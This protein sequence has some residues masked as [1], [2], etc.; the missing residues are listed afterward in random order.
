MNG[1]PKTHASALLVVIGHYDN[2][3]YEPLNEA[4][5]AARAL[6]EALGAGGYDQ[7]HAELLEGGD[8]TLIGTLGDRLLS[9][10]KGDTLLLYWA[11][12]GKKEADGHFLATRI[13]TRLEVPRGQS[14]DPRFHTSRRDGRFRRQRRFPEDRGLWA[15]HPD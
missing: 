5:R 7:V 13:D 11:G 2:P 4:G 14:G 15:L 10:D 9:T 3:A 8:H 1:K 6:I 12:H